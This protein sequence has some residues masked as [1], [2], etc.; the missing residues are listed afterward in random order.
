VRSEGKP[1]VGPVII[2]KSKPFYDE[3]KIADRCTF[4]EG[5]DKKLHV[6]T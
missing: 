5:G 4:S 3:M 6:R 1:M 2:G